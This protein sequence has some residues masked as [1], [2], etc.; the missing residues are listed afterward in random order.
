MKS[1]CLLFTAVTLTKQYRPKGRAVLCVT[2]M[3]IST[4]HLTADEAY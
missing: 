2:A 3:V 4:P 1:A